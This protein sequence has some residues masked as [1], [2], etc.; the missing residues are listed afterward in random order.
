[1]DGTARHSME[2]ARRYSPRIRTLAIPVLV[3][4]VAVASAWC[5][6]PWLPP[7]ASPHAHA[8]W[9]LPP[10]NPTL[11]TAPAHAIPFLILCPPPLILRSRKLNSGLISPVMHSYAR[12]GAP[13]PSPHETPIKFPRLQMPT[14]S[15]RITFARRVAQLSLRIARWG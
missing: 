1:M 9:L 7:H 14:A 8:P 12:N 11:A 3:S 13:R 4:R 10:C 15:Q 2:A 5:C 6:A